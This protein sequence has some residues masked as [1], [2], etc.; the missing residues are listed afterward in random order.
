MLFKIEIKYIEKNMGLK[1]R[2]AIRIPIQK[3]M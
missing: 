3:P 2:V 1:E